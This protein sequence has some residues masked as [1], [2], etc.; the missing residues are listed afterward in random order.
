MN[1]TVLIIS[2]DQRVHLALKSLRNPSLRLLEASTGIGA[3][4]ICATQ[5]VD[6]LVIDLD[7]PG[8]DWPRFMEKLSQAFPG[9]PVLTLAAGQDESGLAER[10]RSIL[11][12]AAARKQPAS[13]RAAFP[14]TRVLRA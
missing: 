9:L 8:M 4:F 2:T 14:M 3:L 11:D 12:S 7:T 6:A 1:R 13:A 10:L 5:P